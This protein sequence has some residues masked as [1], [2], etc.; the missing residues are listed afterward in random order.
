ML[1]LYQNLRGIDC[2][3]ILIHHISAIGAHEI[4]QARQFFNDIIHLI[5]S[6]ARSNGYADATFT[7]GTNRLN[8]ILRN[9][10]CI[11]YQGA[12]YIRC[13]ESNGLIPSEAYI[14]FLF[15]MFQSWPYI[16]LLFLLFPL[17]FL[18]LLFLLFRI[19]KFGYNFF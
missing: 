1:V 14:N 10:L 2:V 17:F 4:A 3:F 5:P 12:I 16:L 9:C 18:F 13:D 8:S 7:S 11:G 15:L 6:A 19:I